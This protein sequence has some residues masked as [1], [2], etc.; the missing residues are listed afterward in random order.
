LEVGLE[1]GWPEG[2]DGNWSV[3][4]SGGGKVKADRSIVTKSVVDGESNETEIPLIRTFIL[5]KCDKY[6][7]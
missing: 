4:R 3:G 7:A 2:V 6:P 1:V 5:A